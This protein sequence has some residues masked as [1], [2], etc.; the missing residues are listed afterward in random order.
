MKE[1]FDI[2]DENN[3]LTHEKSLRSDAHTKGLWHRV[4]HIYVFRKADNKTLFLVHLRSKTKE[5]NPNKWDTRFGGHVK[6]G[7][8]IEETIEKELLEEIGLKIELANLISGITGKS[9]LYPNREFVNVF[10]YN[11]EKETKPLKFNDGE[12]QEVKWMSSSEILESMTNNPNI[13]TG[14]KNGFLKTIDMLK[15]KL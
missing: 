7:E 8:T 12:V 6:A 10:F 15:S 9:D 11:L 13:W 2:V 1:F 3:A 14:S 4:V 5:Q